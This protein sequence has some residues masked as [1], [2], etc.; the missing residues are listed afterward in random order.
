[1]RGHIGV[2]GR[3]H[4]EATVTQSRFTADADKEA[5]ARVVSCG[6]S[7]EKGIG[8]EFRERCEKWYRQ[9]R[10]FSQLRSSWIQGSENDRDG[11]LYDAKRDWGA[12]LHIPLSFRTIET[13]VP[14]AISQRPRMLYFPRRQ[15]YAENVANVRVLIDA[16]QD[17]IDIDLPFQ[18]VMRSGRIYGLG[19]GKVCWR[20]EY[21]TRRKVNKRVFRAGY[22]ANGA[23]PGVRLRRPG[24]RGR[25]CLRLHVGSRTARTSTR[26]AG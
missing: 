13:V 25:R 10:A 24:L 8:R 15:A 19:V 9:Y 16:Q 5:L 23:Q 4:V 3:C 18:A 22:H 12:S 11:L 1:M 17:Q 6:E 26:A 7:F 2:G 21:A 20:K 14:A